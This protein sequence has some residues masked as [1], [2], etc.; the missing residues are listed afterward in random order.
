MRVKKEEGE[1]TKPPCT[2]F[3]ASQPNNNSS[4]SDS[5]ITAPNVIMKEQIWL[6]RVASEFVF[7]PLHPATG[8][9]LHDEDFIAVQGKPNLHLEFCQRDVT[10]GVRSPWNVPADV[11]SQG[12]QEV[13]TVAE[14]LESKCSL[15]SGWVFIRVPVRVSTTMRC[16]WLKEVRRPAA[17]ELNCSVSD[18]DGV[19]RIRSSGW[20]CLRKRQTA[21]E[22][23][24]HDAKL[25]TAI[26]KNPNRYEI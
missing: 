4:S 15:S 8:A 24:G 21:Q 5:M 10:D 12:C 13:F 22:P 11:V 23:T 18:F 16:D 17:H 6:N 3:Y 19:E 14:T 2:C 26:L 9:S 7:Q 25:V 20:S 1:G